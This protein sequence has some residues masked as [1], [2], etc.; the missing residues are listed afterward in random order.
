MTVISTT[1]IEVGPEDQIKKV[2]DSVTMNCVVLW[3]P[4]LELKVKWKK[5]NA[6]LN[7]DEV[8]ISVDLASEANQA[9]TIRNLTYD[10][11]GNIIE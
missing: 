3:D 8:R 4:K 11:A 7:V 6:D 9:L 2:R 10:D 1:M 5:N